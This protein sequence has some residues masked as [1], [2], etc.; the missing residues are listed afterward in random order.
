MANTTSYHSKL[1][2][3]SFEGRQDVIADI[4]QLVDDG[5]D[6][7]LRFRREPD[8]EYDKDAVAI[9]ALT[10]GGTVFDDEVAIDVED[11]W[12]HIGYVAQFNACFL[13]CI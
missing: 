8:N 1:V 3:V 12:K 6:I 11:E 5:N 9:D 4:K 10:G 7:D 2:G 13:T